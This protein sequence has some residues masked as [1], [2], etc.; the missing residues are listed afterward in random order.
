MKNNIKYWIGP[1]S[2]NV[3]DSVIGFDGYFGFIPSRRQVDYQGGYVND[4]TTGEFSTYVDGRVPIERDHGGAGQGFKDDDGYESYL[5]DSAYFDII[6]IDP[7]K[8]YQKFDDGLEETIPT[9]SHIYNNNSDVKFEVGTDE[10]IRKFTTSELKILLNTLSK[11]PFFSNIEY[12]VVQS[13]VGLD[14]GKQINTG[15][16]DPQRLE[17]MIRVCKEYN[18]KS[19]EHNGDYLSEKDYRNRFDIGLDSINIAPEFGQIETKCYL[20]EMGHD[21]EDYFQIC[22]DSKRWEKWVNDEFIPQDNKKQLIEICGHYVF[23]EDSFKGIKPNID[24]KIQ[25]KLREKLRRLSET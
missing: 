20:D 12:A 7:W 19:K 17:D 24:E 5:H 16:F 4:W 18:V 11:K 14:L 8:K 22:Y 23:S 3:V 15:K 2:K 1:M 13:G 10:A 25:Q 21:I 6:H 9:M